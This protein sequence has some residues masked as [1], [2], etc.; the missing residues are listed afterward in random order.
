MFKR[1]NYLFLVGVGKPPV[2]VVGKVSTAA[3][4]DWSVYV[5]LR[6]K[7]IKLSTVMSLGDKHFDLVIFDLVRFKTYIVTVW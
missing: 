6:E 3:A 4:K 5:K 7:V 2:K 1:E